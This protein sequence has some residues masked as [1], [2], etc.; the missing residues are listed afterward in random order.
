MSLHRHE[1]L[2][3]RCPKEFAFLEIG[4]RELKRSLATRHIIYVNMKNQGDLATAFGCLVDWNWTGRLKQ[5][6]TRLFRA[7]LGVEYWTFA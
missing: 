6:H 4:E 7:H 5:Q 1:G 3:V 2:T